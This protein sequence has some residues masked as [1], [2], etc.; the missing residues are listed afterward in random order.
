MRT[1]FLGFATALAGVSAVAVNA[2]SPAT[3]PSTASAPATDPARQAI[4]ESAR[5][6]LAQAY[7][8][9]ICE[10]I[11]AFNL[12]N[13]RYPT[14]AE[15]LAALL[16]RPPNAKA[17]ARNWPY[18]TKILPDPWG[19][20]FIYHCPGQGAAPYDLISAGP[21]GKAGTDDDVTK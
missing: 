14:A 1:L 11:D 2:D 18:L 17:P 15:G 19:H 8:D 3:A 7:I 20:P 6:V 12:D 16:T 5:Q 4:V 13:G 10:A 9:E 21:D